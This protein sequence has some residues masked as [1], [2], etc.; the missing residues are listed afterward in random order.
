MEPTLRKQYIQSLQAC[1]AELYTDLADAERDVHNNLAP[2]KSD[3][4]IIKILT[5]VSGYD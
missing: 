5:L 2:L 1:V 3:S 4:A